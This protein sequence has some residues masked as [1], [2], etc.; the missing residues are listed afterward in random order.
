MKGLQS[1]QDC[2]FP[3][4]NPVSFRL[5]FFVFKGVFSS[6]RFSNSNGEIGESNSLGHKFPVVNP[7]MQRSPPVVHD[8]LWIPL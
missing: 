5:Q 8:S 3:F 6:T 7:R 4:E 1:L 2:F